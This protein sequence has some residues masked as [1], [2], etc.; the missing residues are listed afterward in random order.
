MRHLPLAL[1]VALLLAACGSDPSP[2]AVDA[3]QPDA[4]AVDVAAVVDAA[5]DT[6]SDVTQ[7]P[8]AMPDAAVDVAVADVARDASAADAPGDAPGDAS[9]DTGDSSSDAATCPAVVPGFVASTTPPE[10]ILRSSTSVTARSDRG[11]EGSSGGCGVSVDAVSINVRACTPG[12]SRCVNVSVTR[13]AGAYV[14]Y[15]GEEGTGMTR[16]SPQVMVY[17]GARYLEIGTTARQRENV[18]VVARFPG[19]CVETF[20]LMGAG[21]PVTG[22]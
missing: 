12:S 20:E 6:S 8:D 10:T 1:L 13:A 18:S 15:L 4:L 11:A 7:A 2:A 14:A 16:S 5:A 22:I 17:R 3:A 19:A 21:C 9:G